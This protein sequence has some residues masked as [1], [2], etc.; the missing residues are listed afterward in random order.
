MLMELNQLETFL[1]V[2]EERSF[3]RA[4]VRLHRSQ[5]AVSQV[6]RKLESDLGELLFDR[7]LRDGALT[8]AGQLL[9]EYAVKLLGLRNEAANA[10]DQLR[11]LDRGRLSLG[12][13]EYTCLYLLPVLD[14]FR[15]LC[16]Q[17]T[18]SVQRSLASRIPEE[19]LKRTVEIGIVSFRPEAKEF[20]SIVVYSDNVAFVVNPRHPLA[21]RKSI[22]IR[23]LGAENFIAHN[24]SSSMRRQVIEAFSRYKTPLNMGVELP[25]IEAI[26][27]FVAMGNGVAVLPA[28]TVQREVELGE[29]VKVNVKELQFPRLLRLVHKKESSLS[30]A[31]M[32]FLKVVRSLATERGAPFQ[33]QIDRT[34]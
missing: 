13:N 19:L 21:G 32:A 2:V 25:S 14:E 31:A 4:A 10:L 3:S 26:K 5:P 8:A 1:A 29:L 30:H 15:R 23:D 24:V 12:A 33:Y 9:Q 20:R 34:S 18:V 17:I 7:A 28:M 16:P 22:S 11:S 6:I 27:R